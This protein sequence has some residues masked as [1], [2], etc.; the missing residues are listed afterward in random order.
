MVKHTQ[1]IHHQKPTNCR[2]SLTILW[3]WRLKC[4]RKSGAKALNKNS[5]HQITKTTSSVSF[6]H[7]NTS[8]LMMNFPCNILNW[9]NVENRN[10]NSILAQRSIFIPPE[11][12]R[13]PLV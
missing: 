4:L 10:I 8:S 9:F 7:V 12:V 5:F 13:K 3:V 11:N 2:V 6:E 1:T